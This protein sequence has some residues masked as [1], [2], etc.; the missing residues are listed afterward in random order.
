MSTIINTRAAAMMAW[1][2]SFTQTPEQFAESER[3]RRAAHEEEKR[4]QREI[5]AAKEKA[6]RDIADIDNL[7]R[8]NYNKPIE[9]L[10]GIQGMREL[11]E[12][13]WF[14]KKSRWYAAGN[15]DAMYASTAPDRY[16]RF[17]NFGEMHDSTYAEVEA[18]V[19]RR[20]MT[21]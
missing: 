4:K 15:F 13:E 2:R 16:G 3:L 6:A 20:C 12:S 18:E 9:F 17:G 8:M 11:T 7:R 14:D 5:D 1:L 19:R 21:P 10:L